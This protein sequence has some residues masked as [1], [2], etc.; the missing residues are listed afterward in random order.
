VREDKTGWTVV[1]VANNARHCFQIGQVV[2]LGEDHDDIS[3]YW[4]PK[5]IAGG[6]LLPEDYIRVEEEIDYEELL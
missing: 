4:R 5:G 6:W 3:R 1:I 2:T